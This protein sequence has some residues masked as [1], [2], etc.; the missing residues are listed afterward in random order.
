MALLQD[1]KTLQVHSQVQ[2]GHNGN[3][4]SA[5]KGII[6]AEMKLYFHCR[7]LTVMNQFV[8]AFPLSYEIFTFKRRHGAVNPDEIEDI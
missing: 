1:A 3:K 2:T 7:Y 5:S 6:A 8:H 4:L